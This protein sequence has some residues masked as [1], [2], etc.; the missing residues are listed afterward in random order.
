MQRMGVVGAKKMPSKDFLGVRQRRA[1]LDRHTPLRGHGK[2]QKN[3][4]QQSTSG[5]RRARAAGGMGGGMEVT[6]Y[7]RIRNLVGRRRRA[8]INCRLPLFWVLK[9]PKKNETTINQ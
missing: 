9:A 7:A 8:A 5:R 6:P 1:A 2:D 4:K 3:S